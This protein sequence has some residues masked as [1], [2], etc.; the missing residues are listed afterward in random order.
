MKRELP[1]IITALTGIIII[2]NYFLPELTGKITQIVRNWVIVIS[3]FATILG[4]LNLVIISLRKTLEPITHW[5]DRIANII[6]IA[7]LI[8]TIIIGMIYN[9]VPK[10][11]YVFK[12]LL[13]NTGL[14]PLIT[15]Q[16]AMV[17]TNIFNT[18]IFYS[19]YNPLSAAM[20]SLLAFF[21]AS[22]SYRA[23][24]A[25][26]LEATLLL[27]AASI[28]ILGRVPIGDYIFGFIG[29][30]VSVIS[31]YITAV[32]NAAAQRAILIAVGIGT[33]IISLKLLFG[34]EKAHLGKSE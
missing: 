24:R 12:V 9:V 7:S 23:F 5:D 32:I 13:D 11:D 25:R 3:S 8:L 10:K 33:I 4:I 31:E 1:L 16:V 26:N 19:I 15:F 6:L 22:A 17:D 14:I 29:L 34:I 2:I 20:F 21:I 28:V 27:L 18:V 30:K